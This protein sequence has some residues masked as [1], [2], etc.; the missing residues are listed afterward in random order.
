MR[1]AILLLSALASASAGE[2]TAQEV[3]KATG[4]EA[5]L[6]VHVGTTDGQLELGLA[7]GGTL[8]V[9]GLAL[10]QRAVAEAR[11]AIEAVGLYGL[12]SVD[13]LHET[14]TLP[15][16]DNVV[17]LLV[18]DL[19]A[20]GEKAPPQ[21][22]MMRVLAPTGVAYLKR[23]G[24][25]A[26]TVK[27]V[28][29]AMDVWRHW[30]YGPAGNPV[31]KDKVVAPT[32]SLRWWAGP[33]SPDNA[34][35]KMGLRIAGGRLVHACRDYG[36]RHRV[37]RGTKRD[38]VAR[39]AF[40]GILLWK[41]PIEDVPGRGD[42]PPHFSLTLADGRV[43]AIVKAG[44]PLELLDAATGE[45]LL[46]YDLPT[47]PKYEKRRYWD[48]D[49][50]DFHAI[51]RVFGD[52]LLYTLKDRVYLLALATGERRWAWRAGDGLLV[53]WALVGDGKVAV[54][55]TDRPL[56]KARGSTATILGSIVALDAKTG[57]E[58]WRQGGSDGSHIYRMVYHDGRLIV[59]T[60]RPEKPDRIGYRE[61]YTVTCLKA[62]DGSVAWRN[63]EGHSAHGHYQIVLAR[64]GKV[65]VGNQ[66]G[67][68]LDLATGKFLAR[69]S[70]GQYDGGCADLKALPDYVCYGLTFIRDD[71]TKITRGQARSRCDVG[72][73]PAYGLMYL[74]P[75][76]CLCS[77]FVNGYV[78][79]AADPGPTPVED[80]QRLE[81]RDA[82]VEP[83]AANVPWPAPTEWPIH[84]GNPQRGASTASPPPAEAKTL[85]TTRVAGRRDAPG[86][87]VTDWRENDTI[88]GLVT[89]PT[90]AEGRVFV[91]AP[92]AHR[93]EAHDAKTGERAWAFT[94]GGRIDSPPT[95]YGGLCLFGCRDGWVTC[96]RAGDGKLVW[97]FL[98][99]VRDK[100]I[101]VQSQLESAW[102]VHGS[103]MI[104][105][106]NVVFTA[107]RQTAVDEGI[108]V[109]ALDPF[110][111]AVRWKTRIWTD[112]DAPREEEGRTNSY[113]PDW[114]RTQQLLVSDGTRLY[115]TID[116][117]KPS[118]GP[119]ELVGLVPRT[120][121]DRG[122]W[123]TSTRKHEHSARGIAVLWP[124]SN[125][126]LSQRVEA[127]GRNDF[128]G[129]AYSDLWAEKMVLAGRRLFVL[130]KGGYGRKH[131]GLSLF[132]LDDEGRPA[133]EPTWTVK[134]R[135]SSRHWIALVLAGDRLLAAGHRME[136]P[137]E[138]FL[139]VYAAADGKLLAEHK[140]PATPVR[141]G[142]AAAYGRLYAACEDGTLRCLGE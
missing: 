83:P 55:V 68:S 71:G 7:K 36:L 25:W 77:N 131:P 104:H 64:G 134:V 95:L 65:Y 70:W 47:P 45:T 31:S 82:T 49:A 41:R 54:A 40:N 117:L 124:N 85:W 129:V 69:H 87:I 39:D 127:V 21:A 23:G 33:T 103:V 63:S 107:G 1:R 120:A 136:R 20:L 67:F 32:T 4:V 109:Y 42:D 62:A 132:A 114:R 133:V 48:A 97:R 93:I 79:L 94:T 115:H 140:L 11:A 106:G 100:R 57:R 9:H 34:A 108:Q 66:T 142:L 17:N 105:K 110:T 119:G 28:P 50:S 141:D 53:G 44:G 126:F 46:T 15:Y 88:V 96:L 13:G 81:R 24:A 37:R 116:A 30:D 137:D 19:D 6:A 90:V 75:S 51:V 27:P 92:D 84:L 16:A 72:A 121:A 89:A 18:A 135:A 112:P 130:A 12:A 74:N 123:I 113:Q 35:D 139:Q 102:P 138:P 59:P 125:G 5:G 61:K 52:S 78:A 118:Y 111:G 99:A 98:A 101:V 86:P 58:V 91:A 8:L 60:F 3:L 2:P 22:E 14:K 26:K 76:G 80:S 56:A 128:N 122:G 73:F 10:D 43:L 38:L 29:E